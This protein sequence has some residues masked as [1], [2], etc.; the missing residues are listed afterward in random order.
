[1]RRR[2]SLM[3][4]HKFGAGCAANRY[5]RLPFDNGPNQRIDIGFPDSG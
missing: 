5:Q 2:L 1:M 4:F 3:A